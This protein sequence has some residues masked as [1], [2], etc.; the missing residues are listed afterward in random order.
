MK[1]KS[2]NERES[3]R[4]DGKGG[5]IRRHEARIGRRALLIDKVPSFVEVSELDAGPKKYLTQ[6]ASFRPSLPTW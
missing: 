3:N 2:I 4:F 1:R 5:N 6:L